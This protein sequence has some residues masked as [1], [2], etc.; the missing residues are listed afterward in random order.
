[1]RINEVELFNKALDS[2]DPVWVEM[3]RKAVMCAGRW[4]KASEARPARAV[5]NFFILCC[6]G[7]SEGGD[8]RNLTTAIGQTRTFVT[9]TVIPY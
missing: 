8:Y 1:M 4:W 2:D 7:Y 5:G 9:A 3:G 6:P